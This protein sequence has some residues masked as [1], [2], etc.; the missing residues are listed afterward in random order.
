MKEE[1][2]IDAMVQVG[3]EMYLAKHDPTLWAKIVKKRYPKLGFDE[4]LQQE[5]EKINGNISP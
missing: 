1:G 2:L 4:I 3:N 5:R